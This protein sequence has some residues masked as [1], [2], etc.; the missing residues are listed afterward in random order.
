MSKD[1]R[2]SGIAR[3]LELSGQK[4]GLLLVSFVTG[5]VHALLTMV[6]Y[7]FIL[8]ILTELLNWNTQQTTR[9]WKITAGNQ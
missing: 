3:L 2:K 8:Y 4:K 1:K 9:G 5:T 6:P 7:M